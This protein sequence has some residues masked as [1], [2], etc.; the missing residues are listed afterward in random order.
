M[1]S[2]LIKDSLDKKS[3]ELKSATIEIKNYKNSV[4]TYRKNAEALGQRVLSQTDKLEEI[5][6]KYKETEEQLVMAEEAKRFLKTYLSCS[7]DDALE[8]ISHKATEILRAIP[9][10]ANATITL[11]GTKE[12][13]SGAVKEQINAVLNNDGEIDVPI[14]SLSGGERSAVDMA[15]DLAVT[16]FI[17]EKSNIGCD[18]LFLDEIFGGFDSVGIEQALEMLRTVAVDKKIFIIEHNPIAKEF[19]SDKIVVVRDK[20]TSELA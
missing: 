15:I 3:S 20:E 18:I 19:V 8:S 16:I 4:D 9:T 10:M 12:T 14:K 7:F 2:S 13:G 1:E 11:V 17:Q 6:V 5:K